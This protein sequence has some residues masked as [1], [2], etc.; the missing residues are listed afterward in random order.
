[1]SATPRATPSFWGIVLALVI[2]G[3]VLAVPGTAAGQ[4]SDNPQFA[5]LEGLL[6]SG[7]LTPENQDRCTNAVLAVLFPQSAD[8]FCADCDPKF[9]SE[10]IRR[11]LI[12]FDGGR[13]LRTELTACRDR[14]LY[15][16][17][18]RESDDE[19]RALERSFELYLNEEGSLEAR[20]RSTSGDPGGEAPGPATANVVVR[21]GQRLSRGVR[22][23]CRSATAGTCS[24]RVIARRRLFASGQASVAAGT[25]ATVT[26]RSTAFGRRVLRRVGR[27]TVRVLV[28][29]PSGL[30]SR[31]ITLLR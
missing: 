24:V 22:V 9:S 18:T 10:E 28:R 30:E 5:C 27:I 25:T 3:S 2:L 6:L 23:S 14:R 8:R 16:T 20:R 4:G 13:A 31:T 11:A 7:G 17:G 19:C 1:M 26:A 12:A 15:G 29:A 21:G